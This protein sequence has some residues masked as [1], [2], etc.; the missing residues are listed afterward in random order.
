MFEGVDP[1]TRSCPFCA[2]SMPVAAISCSGC[3]KF[4]A[5]SATTEAGLIDRL[6]AAVVARGLAAKPRWRGFEVE[7]P[8]R[9]C[10]SAAA[11]IAVLG[12]PLLLFGLVHNPGVP[13]LWKAVTMALVL[14]VLL[15][16]VKLGRHSVA[17]SASRH[18]DNAPVITLLGYDL[19]IALIQLLALA[20]MIISALRGLADAANYACLITLVLM[21]LLY[22]SAA[23]I[24]AVSAAIIALLYG[25][26]HLLVWDAEHQM[27]ANQTSRSEPWFM[28]QL[29]SVA[30][31]LAI[32]T[33]FPQMQLLGVNG[34]YLGRLEGDCHVNFYGSSVVFAPMSAILLVAVWEVLT[35]LAYAPNVLP[36]VIGFG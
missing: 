4:S 6:N 29:W 18:T 26:Y 2:A 9:Y 16:R 36:Q 15:G 5:S 17:E 30:G 19:N 22:K 28:A 14:A 33:A 34:D 27:L 1:Q 10:L 8:H 25:M 21:P 3:G 11:I 7:R 13:L 31:V 12:G 20:T 32:L 23:R 24:P 35:T